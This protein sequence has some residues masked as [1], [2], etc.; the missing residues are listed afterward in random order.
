MHHFHFLN[1]Y[2]GR[3]SFLSSSFLTYQV[4]S[5]Y[6]WVF[7][8]SSVPSEFLLYFS[9]GFPMSGLKVWI[10]LPQFEKP[11]FHPS[12]SQTFHF[13]LSF[14]S[15]NQLLLSNDFWPMYSFIFRNLIFCSGLPKV[16]SDF[17]VAKWNDLFLVL[18]FL[19]YSAVL[20][21]LRTLAETAGW[22]GNV[23]FLPSYQHNSNG[24]PSGDPSN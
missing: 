23:P 12:A 6:L 20:K 14:H 19:N 7:F 3:R 5:Q 1:S 21:L 18:I 17:L 8:Q 4:P 22:P 2:H 11:L 15:P 10:S 24:I 9:T 16:I 13:F